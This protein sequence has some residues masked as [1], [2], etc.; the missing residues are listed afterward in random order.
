MIIIN[1]EPNTI[2]PFV[3]SDQ[4]QI[5]FQ[6]E[7]NY[8]IPY[9][10]L[11]NPNNTKKPLQI[12]TRITQINPT[13]QD[14]YTYGFS[15]KLSP[16]INEITQ[17]SSKFFSNFRD[18]ENFNNYISNKKDP[19]I[20][21]VEER[22]FGDIDDIFL[23]VDNL[24]QLNLNNKWDEQYKINYRIIKNLL[25]EEYY[26]KNSSIRNLNNHNL[27]GINE[28]FKMKF[29]NNYM[30]GPFNEVFNDY[31][32]PV[33]YNN[34]N[35]AWE[36]ISTL[37]LLNNYWES[38]LLDLND[39]ERQSFI[40]K[41]LYPIHTNSDLHNF[42]FGGYLEPFSIRSI[43]EH[44]KQLK[45][46]LNGLKC[47]IVSGGTNSKN[48][49]NIIDNYINYNIY[50]TTHNTANNAFFYSNDIFSDVQD[51]SFQKYR[52][53]TI[54]HNTE[55]NSIFDL[56]GNITN[57]KSV[58]ITELTN[59]DKY[60]LWRKNINIGYLNESEHINPIFVFNDNNSNLSFHSNFYNN[61]YPA[62]LTDRESIIEKLISNLFNKKNI[63]LSTTDIQYSSHGLDLDKSIN[64]IGRDSK[65]YAGLKE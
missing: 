3:D 20:T 60:P 31:C 47:S 1:I 14:R 19:I 49:D 11:D 30:K 56:N 7:S 65:T 51:L 48:V 34:T 61:L 17:P 4:T 27:R 38:I 28:D 55:T 25:N 57:Q 15:L 63:L 46:E 16:E 42:Y 18:D 53:D 33:I 9:T 40:F 23:S 45:D 64:Q 32:L 2:T 10:N 54:R 37:K 12:T 22:I 59:D 58:I 62:G 5:N 39:P 29:P 41:I 8:Y 21:E 44:K 24:I 26:P 6:V 52:F 35:N 36:S 50:K 13:T 43:I